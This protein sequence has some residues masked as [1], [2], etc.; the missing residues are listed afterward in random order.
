MASPSQDRTGVVDPLIDAGDVWEKVM[1]GCI[2]AY[3]VLR[4]VV[5]C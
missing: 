2:D 4:G 3:N 5:R 1:R